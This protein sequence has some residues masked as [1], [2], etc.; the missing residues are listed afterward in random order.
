[1][2]GLEISRRFFEEYG[3]PMLHDQFPELTG[4][5]AAALTG[6]GSE[7]FG[8]DDAV[9]ADHD[10]D[11][12]FCLFL[13]GEEIVDRQTAFRLERAYAKLPRE[14][15]GFVRPVIQ[16]VGGSRRGVMRLGDFF[17]D[18]VG[19]PDGYLTAEQWLRIPMYALAEAT[20][21]EVFFDGSGL[22]TGIRQRLSAMPEDVR[23]KR[24]AGQL[25]LMAQSGQYNYR[26]C[27]A[28]GEEAAAQLAVGE[29]VRAAMTAVFLLNR[30]YMPYYKWSFRTMRALP[31]LSVLAETMEYL[32]TT[33]NDREAA[34]TKYELIEDAAA[35]VI[36]ELQS[37]SLTQAIC[38]DL[39]KHAYSVNDSVGDAEIRNLHI[40]STV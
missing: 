8:Y 14:Y 4:K 37:Q 6:C 9:S 35:S 28:H 26:R 5:L 7:C 31:R 29:F 11:P 36:G 20:N 40:L 12:G 17:T 34:E 3:A 24:L 13:P 27:L 33:P 19:T 1:M 15:A 10:F 32:L 2:Q 22:L 18:R 30:R 16:P 23:R 39:E 21:G 38:G 25:L